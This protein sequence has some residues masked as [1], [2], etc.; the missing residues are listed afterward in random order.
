[1]G[2]ASARRLEEE[3]PVATGNPQG[4]DAPNV[5]TAAQLTQLASLQAT[6]TAAIATFHSIRAGSNSQSVSYKAAHAAMLNAMSA[7]VQYQAY[8]A[9]GQKPGIYDEGGASIT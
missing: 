2:R 7:V 8:I 6:S 3:M 4:A 5:P 9:G 1:M